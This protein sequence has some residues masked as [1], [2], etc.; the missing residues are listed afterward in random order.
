MPDHMAGDMPD[1]QA[2]FI[3]KMG[4]DGVALEGLQSCLG[5]TIAAVASSVGVSAVTNEPGRHFSAT[6]STEVTPR[7]AR[8]SLSSSGL[9]NMTVAGDSPPPTPATMVICW[10]S[11]I[12]PN[13]EGGTARSAHTTSKLT[14]T[15]SSLSWPSRPD[16]RP[17]STRR[18]ARE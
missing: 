7:A 9:T 2:L 16:Q 17:S 13:S 5:T 15:N 11:W 18:S 10:P 12:L 4:H 3:D 8:V 14:M 6:L 1:S